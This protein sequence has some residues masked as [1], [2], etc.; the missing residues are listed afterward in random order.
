MTKRCN[1]TLL[2][3]LIILSGCI[4]VDIKELPGT[5]VFN[6][7]NLR[8]T[9]IGLKNGRYNHIRCINN[10]KYINAD[11]WKYNGRQIDFQYFTFFDGGNG[12]WVS[13]VIE[14]ETRSNLIMQRSKCII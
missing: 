8:D 5:Y 4:R 3:L 2:T 6:Q 13:R 9:L 11:I 10:K 14:T 1:A 12:I 7:E